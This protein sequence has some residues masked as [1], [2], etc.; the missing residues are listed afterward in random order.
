MKQIRQNDT[1]QGNGNA[2]IPCNHNNA[3]LQKHLTLT[4]ALK[5]TISTRMVKSYF[6]VCKGFIEG[7]HT[8]HYVA[9]A[10]LQSISPVSS[11]SAGHVKFNSFNAICIQ[12]CTQG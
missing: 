12:H 9:S 1:K 10:Y 3:E 4:I 7:F 6:I 8:K 5:L 2:C 11:G